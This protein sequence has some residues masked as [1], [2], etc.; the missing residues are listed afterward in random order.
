MSHPTTDRFIQALHAAEE[1]H[2]PA[3]LAALYAAESECMNLSK[4]EPETGVEGARKFWGEYLRAFKTVR[5]EFHNVLA[6]DDHAV[7][8]WTST[9][10]LPTGKP[11]EYRGVSILEY[12]GDKVRKFHS[13]YDSAAFVAALATTEP[14]AGNGPAKPARQG[15]LEQPKGT[16]GSTMTAPAAVA[17]PDAHQ[18]SDPDSGG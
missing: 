13:Y 4:D 9:G 12:A 1:S 18:E 15:A 2:D 11:I 3:P 5:S 17:P 8:E 14:A 16:A 10:E 7:L 6:T